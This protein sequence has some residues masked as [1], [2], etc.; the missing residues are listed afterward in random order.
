MLSA[1]GDETDK[2]LLLEIGADEA[3]GVLLKPRLAGATDGVGAE[4]S[5]VGSVSGFAARL[6]QFLVSMVPL[7]ILDLTGAPKPESIPH[8]WIRLLFGSF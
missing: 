6:Q 1:I 8:P 5:L 2:I 3:A 4:R 7:A